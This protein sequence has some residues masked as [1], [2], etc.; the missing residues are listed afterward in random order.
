MSLPAGFS[1]ASANRP[2]GL[3]GSSSMNWTVISATNN[4]RVLESSLLSSP[5]LRD[6]SQVILQRGYSGAAA[7][8]NHAIDKAQSDLLV[9][10]HQDVYLPAGWLASLRRTLELLSKVDP[11]WG[12][13]G[14]WGVNKSPTDGT[15]FLYCTA[16]GRLG[17]AFEGVREVRTLDEVLLIMRKSS[18]L[19][20]DEQLPG[21]HMYGP[22][23]CLEAKRQGMRS[24]AISAFC[25]HNTSS[26]KMLPLDFWRCYLLM[27][28]K[29]RSALPIATS[30]TEITFGCWPMIRWNV[31]R[32]AN[33]LLRRHRVV[34]RH[35]DPSQLSLDPSW[36]NGAMA[37]SSEAKQ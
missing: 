10:V 3:A 21:F 1:A 26:Y 2:F 6:A 28:K 32:A 29:W 16:N 35:E 17:N 11:N 8:Y 37:S 7:A 18:N 25:I 4:N 19:R 34:T 12:V 22:D 23:I 36:S 33:I 30:C 13:L 9:F 27:R 5:D 20:F 15:G 14:I 31:T 24:Y